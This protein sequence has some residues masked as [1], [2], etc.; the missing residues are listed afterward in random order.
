M[1]V[2]ILVHLVAI[3]LGWIV[4]VILGNLLWT[5]MFLALGWAFFKKP[6]LGGIVTFLYVD[7]LTDLGAIMDWSFRNGIFFVPLF[8]AFI[9]SLAFQSI[10]G[11]QEWFAK[12]KY[13][14]SVVFYIFFIMANVFMV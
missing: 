9:A 1:F 8:A 5:F 11:K 2:D 7:S 10:F 3:D 13:V 14:I 12:N 6:V 4:G